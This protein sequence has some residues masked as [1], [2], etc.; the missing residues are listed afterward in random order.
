MNNLPLH[1]RLL[2]RFMRVFFYILYHQFAWM[3]DLVSNLVS[4]GMWKDWIM[5][6]VPDLKGLSVLELGHGPGHLQ[7]ILH[8]SGVLVFGIDESHQMGKQAGKR[9]QKKFETHHLS[10]GFAQLLPFPDSSFNQVVSTF[11]SEYIFDRKTISEVHRVLVSGGEFI[12]MPVAWITGHNWMERCA[13]WLFRVTG[14]S[15]EWGTEFMSPFQHA[16]FIT[17]LK[18]IKHKRWTLLIITGLKS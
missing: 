9:L 7:V 2:T 1:H 18:Q 10:R 3:Y 8:E 4:L 15:N 17:E 14:Q 16:G 13:A 5:S 12:I 6:V 11:P